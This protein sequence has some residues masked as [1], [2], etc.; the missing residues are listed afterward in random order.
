MSL[1]FGTKIATNFRAKFKDMYPRKKWYSFIKRKK[2]NN[3]TT[4]LKKLFQ[5]VL[6]VLAHE[7]KCEGGR[8]K[9]NTNF[10]GIHTLH[11]FILTPIATTIAYCPA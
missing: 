2:N 5:I 8:R 9:R 11:T 4:T 6:A 1:K 3:A 10:I 7:S